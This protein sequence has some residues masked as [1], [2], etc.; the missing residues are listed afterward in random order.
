M[1]DT[2]FSLRGRNWNFTCNLNECQSLKF[3]RSAIRLYLLDIFFSG[4][5]NIHG[6]YYRNKIIYDQYIISWHL[7]SLVQSVTQSNFIRQKLNLNE[8]PRAVISQELHT[9][10]TVRLCHG[11]LSRR[12]PGY[13]FNIIHPVVSSRSYKYT[14]LQI[15]CDFD[16]HS[17]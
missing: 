14:L 5:N 1:L 2:D 15:W 6:K 3:Q 12:S 10:F 13:Y 9:F 4:T 8:W 11:R 17:R 7:S 16:L